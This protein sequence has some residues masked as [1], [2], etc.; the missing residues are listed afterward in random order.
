MFSNH[1]EIMGAKDDLL[2]AYEQLRQSKVAQ[3]K[4]KTK[5]AELV[6]TDE[7]VSCK[8][9]KPNA[10]QEGLKV[11]SFEFLLTFY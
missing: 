10:H 9:K 4:K 3:Q 8:T 1:A 6:E 7:M 11:S 5:K 2:Q